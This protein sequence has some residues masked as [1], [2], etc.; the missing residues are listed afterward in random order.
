[1]ASNPSPVTDVDAGGS[2][3]APDGS[4]HRLGQCVDT[5][6]PCSQ[7]DLILVNPMAERR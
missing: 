3:W 1:M 6:Y 4:A 2:G 5:S 7:V